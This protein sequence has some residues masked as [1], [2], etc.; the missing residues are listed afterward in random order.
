[1]K[2]WGWRWMWSL[3]LNVYMSGWWGQA[4]DRIWA[5]QQHT[6]KLT[7]VRTKTEILVTQFQQTTHTK[8]VWFLISHP[9]LLPL[10]VG[11]DV[12]RNHPSSALFAWIKN[13][14]TLKPQRHNY[15]S[16]LQVL[17]HTKIMS[18]LSTFTFRSM[19]AVCVRIWNNLF[20]LKWLGHLHLNLE[21]SLWR[22]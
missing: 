13:L 10:H 6:C 18:L 3:S 4:N 9:V 2:G 12:I 22:L 15:E 5:F 16:M 8:A 17:T 7:V 21:Q 20:C 14:Q 11:A 19:S 1:M